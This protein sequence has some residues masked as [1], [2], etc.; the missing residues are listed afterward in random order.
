MYLKSKSIQRSNSCK[1][2]RKCIGNSSKSWRKWN[3]KKFRARGICPRL[4]V[5]EIVQS[6]IPEVRRKVWSAIAICIAT[7]TVSTQTLLLAKW[8]N[9]FTLSKALTLQKQQFWR[10][11]KEA[12]KRRVL[13]SLQKWRLWSWVMS[14][15]ASYLHSCAVTPDGRLFTWGAVKDGRGGIGRMASHAQLP[16]QIT[17]AFEDGM[18]WRSA[19]PR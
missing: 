12:R 7:N 9:R 19:T 15:S 6:M 13:F 14:A 17:I 1:I 11:R 16:Q 5:L 3:R 8:P 18:W 10:E 4:F 2:F